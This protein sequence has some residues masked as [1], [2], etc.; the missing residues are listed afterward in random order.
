MNITKKHIRNPQSYLYSLAPGDTFYVAVPLSDTDAPALL[1]YGFRMDGSAVRHI[2]RPIKSATKKNMYGYYVIH[3]DLPKEPRT[4]EREYHVVDWHGEDH[5]GTCYHTR[6]CYQRTLVP[7]RELDFTV[8][9]KVVY[10]PALINSDEYMDD[11][12]LVMNML[13]EIFERCEIWTSNKIPA[14]PP[15]DCIEVPWE[16]LRSGSGRKSEWEHYIDETTKVIA[17][18]QRTVIKQ[19]HEYLWELKPDFCVLGNQNFWGYVVYGFTSLGLYIFECNRP[20]NATYVFRGNW[21]AAS[22]LTKTEI[23]CGNLQ[24]ARLFHT[25]SWRDNLGKLIAHSMKEAV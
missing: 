23:L 16:I 10:S 2:P 12:K 22:A 18:R 24:E 17:E 5:Y 11:I 25:E 7:P 21:E 4:F 3:K 1:K 20:D 19:R 13:L 15:L 8:E 9:D 14:H 6:D